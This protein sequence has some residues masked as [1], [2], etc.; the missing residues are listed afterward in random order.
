MKRSKLLVLPAALI[1]ISLLCSG[2]TSSQSTSK[3]K[4]KTKTH[5]TQK[6]A[7]KTADTTP[8]EDGIVISMKKIDVQ[9]VNASI[10]TYRMMYWSKGT[11][12]EAYV[13]AP[14]EPG[15]FPLVIICHGGWTTS[16][17]RVHVSLVNNGPHNVA[18][19]E[20]IIEN[21]WP[22]AITLAPMYR[23]Y[24]NSDGT[25]NGLSGNTIDTE[26]AIKAIRSFLNSKKETP[27]IQ[28]GHIY[29]NGTSMGG[30][31]ALKVAS[32]RKDVL[33]V[34]AVSPFVGWDIVG[35][36]DQKHTDN[37]TW[38]SYLNNAVSVYG[39]FDAESTVYKQESIPYKN[40]KAP[41]LLIQGT[42]D[43]KTPWQTVQILYKKMNE[44][45]QDVTFKPIDGGFHD[46]TNKTDILNQTL[47]DWWK[48]HWH[49]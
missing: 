21:P 4:A 15:T 35:S 44:N 5:T 17:N 20:R 14:K 10:Q 11:K 7:K 36:W 6:V 37:A 45:N 40:I 46:L 30:G 25:V 12:T 31:V 33:S 49:S 47:N 42:S 32:E 24:G 41:T 29:L 18:E 2:C 8:K 34:V 22:N 28:D 43:T 48:D 9:N 13:A 38:K 16:E 27:H 1:F 39:P 19:E 23:G 26:N 3:V